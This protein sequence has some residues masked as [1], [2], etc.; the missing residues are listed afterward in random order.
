MDLGGEVL[1][2]WMAL[3]PALGGDPLGIAVYTGYLHK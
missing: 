3:G 1:V 2:E